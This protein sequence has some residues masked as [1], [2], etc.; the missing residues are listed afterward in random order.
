MVRGWQTIVLSAGVVGIVGGE[1]G[2]GGGLVGGPSV[3]V[4]DE[5][6]DCSQD[7]DH[8]DQDTNDDGHQAGVPEDSVVAVDDCLGDDVAQIELLLFIVH[9]VM[10]V[11]E[12]VVSVAA[13][14][15]QSDA[16][17]AGVLTH[18]DHPH[19]VSGDTRQ[20]RDQDRAVCVHI[21][22]VGVTQLDPGAMT[23]PGQY[24]DHLSPLCPQPPV[25]AT[26]EHHSCHHGL[27]TQVHLYPL[28]TGVG[29]H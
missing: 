18:R 13:A 9:L 14:Q 28:L 23:A 27:M 1:G 7:D 26:L 16:D 6:D 2:S 12:H 22:R 17:R 11:L 10:V 4:E 15:L 20:Q 3:A 21:G 29:H 5:D 24:P 19:L 25:I 8:R